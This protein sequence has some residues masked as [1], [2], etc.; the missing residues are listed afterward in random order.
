MEYG[1][2]VYR[3][4]TSAVGA[5]G[6]CC[7]DQAQQPYRLHCATR[8]YKNI[9][10]ALGST[11]CNMAGVSPMV[12]DVWPLC[13]IHWNSSTPA[14]LRAFWRMSPRTAVPTW[15]YTLVCC[16]QDAERMLEELKQQK[17]RS[18]WEEAQR[19]WWQQYMD[20]VQPL[21][22][23][24]RP[25]PPTARLVTQRVAS[26]SCQTAVA[27]LERRGTPF[28]PAAAYCVHH[29]PMKPNHAC[30]ALTQCAPVASHPS[31]HALPC[32]QIHEYTDPRCPALLPDQPPHYAAMGIK[33]LV[34]DLEGLLVHKEW[35][36]AK[37]WQVR[38]RGRGR[39]GG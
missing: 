6:Y 30:S 13:A 12:L 14:A 21:A 17:D 9:I 3:Q 20:V 1:L 29:L 33:T 25:W 4:A 15:P 39:V 23:K 10:F 35:T 27:T 31:P 5:C 28:P 19:M 36:R 11:R 38:G 7:A 26:F 2:C 18:P 24:V 34:L 8:P 37:G 22:E 16:S 32:L